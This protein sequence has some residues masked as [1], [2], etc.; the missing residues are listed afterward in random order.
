MLDPNRHQGKFGEDYVRVLA[1]A[2]GL[3]VMKEDID[4]TGVDLGFRAHSEHARAR[5]PTIEA[6]VKT[7]STP[8]IRSGILVF[9]ELSETQFNMLAGSDFTVPRFLF[10]ICVPRDHQSYA[11]LS[12]EGVML[13]RLGY[14]ISLETETPIENP[15][16]RRRRTVRL[17]LGNVLTTSSLHRLTV[18]QATW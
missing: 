7:C 15:D 17:P 2:A 4:A 13:Q 18:T 12:S 6:Q 1:S 10:V 9:R 8:E 16:R 5:F 14:F 3:I 11:V